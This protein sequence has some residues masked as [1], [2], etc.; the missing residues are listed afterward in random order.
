MKR[1]PIFLIGLIIIPLIACNSTHK[2]VSTNISSTKERVEDYCDNCLIFWTKDTIKQ[3]NIELVLLMDTLYQQVRFNEFKNVP[4]DS[5]LIWMAEYRNRLGRYYDRNRLGNDNRSV[6][7]KADSVIELA[8]KLWELDQDGSSM[9]QINKNLISYDR[10]L[11]TEYNEL[12]ALLDIYASSEQKEA[13]K[14]EFFAWHNLQD[15]FYNICS[16]LVGLHYYW[17]S[18]V[19]V[20]NSFKLLELQNVHIYLYKNDRL[21]LSQGKGITDDVIDNLKT[22]NNITELLQKQCEIEEQY[23]KD[24]QEFYNIKSYELLDSVRK[25]VN[26]LPKVLNEWLL[27][28]N[29][30]ISHVNDELT[31]NQLIHNT[32]KALISLSEMIPMQD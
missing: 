20:I 27:K 13:L 18:A 1:L 14:K 23:M 8:N 10:K 29:E 31:Y 22:N 24:N 9:G 4:L 30:Y 26:R 15:L 3:T 25:S 2:K 19:G 11:F 7:D 6:Y 21:V 12:Q 28:R 16:N 5:R 32:D 17:G